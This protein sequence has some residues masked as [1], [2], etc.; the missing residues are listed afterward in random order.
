MNSAPVP[1][2]LDAVVS[3]QGLTQALPAIAVGASL[4]ANPGC[5]AAESLREWAR[6]CGH[7]GGKA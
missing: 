2:R 1:R 3:F 5:P 6:T 7:G 4:L